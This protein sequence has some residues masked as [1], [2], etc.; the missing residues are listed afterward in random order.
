MVRVVNLIALA[1]C[2]RVGFD[3]VPRGDG[4]GPGDVLADVAGDVVP[5][6]H[7][8]DGD[9]VPDVD[10]NCP[11][12]SGSLAD[13]DGDGVGDLCD[14][15]PGAANAI[16]LFATMVPGDQPF[17]INPFTD[18]TFTQEADSL[19]F[20]D[21]AAPPLFGGLTMALTAGDVR[22]AIG[23]TITSV[24]P[25]TSGQQNQV[26]LSAFDQPPMYFVEVNAI[27]GSFQRAH[28]VHF[29]GTTYTGVTG[30]DLASGVHPGDLVLQTTQ[31]V[32]QS[33]TL[34]A[35]WP[36]EAYSAQVSDGLYQG[37]TQINVNTNN[38]HYEIRYVIVIEST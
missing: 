20:G 3:A 35:G 34:A 21:A 8:E 33:V 4:G 38:L 26:A 25:T 32:G 30:Q 23:L 19:R 22:V 10:D 11:H 5:L 13:A 18:G 15:A 14:P 27:A 37:T 16:R 17:A 9:G 31:I 36:G 2:G 24:L 6:G 7:D 28:I 1:G 12:L 29:D